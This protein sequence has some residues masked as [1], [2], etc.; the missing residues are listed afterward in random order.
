MTKKAA[1]QRV[2]KR[3]GE[4]MGLEVGFVHELAREVA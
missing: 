3:A 4:V 1:I 2:L